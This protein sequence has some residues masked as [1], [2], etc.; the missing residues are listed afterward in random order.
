MV[1]SLLVSATLTT[2]PPVRAVGYGAKG[3]GRNSPQQQPA[4]VN[5]P[6]VDNSAATAAQQQVNTARQAVSKAQEDLNAIAGKLRG[7]FNSSPEMVAA[8]GEQRTAQQAF[9]A[10]SKPVLEKVHESDDYKTASAAH[11][12]DE[13]K[14]TDLRTN[15]GSA[16]VIATTATD[17]FNQGS[18]MSKL[19]KYALDGDPQASAAKAKMTTAGGK[20]SQLQ[21]AFNASLTQNTEWSAAKKALDDAKQGLETA[22]TSLRDASAKQATDQAAHNQAAAQQQK[23]EQEHPR[24]NSTAN[25]NSNPNNN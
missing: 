18:T 13:A 17:A 3:S 16:D 19:E 6:P 4:P 20:I 15:N 24:N 12:D 22:S 11:S 10:A 5:V 21:A 14:L 25:N 2:C 8:Q 23:Q 7:E 1:L 9:D